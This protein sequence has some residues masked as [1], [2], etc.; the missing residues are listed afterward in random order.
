MDVNVHH[1]L[2]LFIPNLASMIELIGILVIIYGVVRSIILFVLSGGNLMASDPKI[3]L[4]RALSYS[5]E[6]KLAAEILK[7]VLI[8]T[9][10]EFIIL[11]AIVILRVILTYVI[12]WELETSEESKHIHRLDEVPQNKKKVEK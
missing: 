9:L 8:Q 10:D 6:F 2:E 12:H 1:L 5:L 4:A 7:S 3:D 11:A